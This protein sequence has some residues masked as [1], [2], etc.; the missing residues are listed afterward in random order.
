MEPVIGSFFCQQFIGRA[1]L[2]NA[3]VIDYK[4][5]VRL[6]DRR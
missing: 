6:L 2:N 4:D 1:F 3:A 5:A